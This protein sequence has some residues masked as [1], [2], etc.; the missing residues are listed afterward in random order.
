MPAETI[1]YYAILGVL[2]T[3]SEQEIKAAFRKKAMAYHPD[4]NAGKHSNTL[5]FNEI[6]LAYEILGNPAK[7]QDYHYARFFSK[8]KIE[9]APTPAQIVDQTKAFADLILAIDPYRVDYDK[10][11]HQAET[12]VSPLYINALKARIAKNELAFFVEHLLAVL[13]HIPYS[14]VP[15]LFD[16]LLVVAES[17]EDLID[18]I[19]ANIKRKKRIETWEKYKTLTAFLIAVILCIIMYINR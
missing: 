6:K 10:L 15:H 11:I 19:K 17:N 1:D 2:P 5:K 3:A 14:L 8:V 9:T 12:L 7:R 16:A 13:E 18:L 4:T